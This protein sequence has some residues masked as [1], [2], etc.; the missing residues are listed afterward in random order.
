VPRALAVLVAVAAAAGCFR[1]GL[2]APVRAGVP[3]PR[4]DDTDRAR[5]GLHGPVRAVRVIDRS[6][7]FRGLAEYDRAGRILHRVERGSERLYRYDQRGRLLEEIVRNAALEQPPSAGWGALPHQTVYAYDAAGRVAVE[8]TF[9]G[10]R[11][12]IR[13]RSSADVVDHDDAL[14]VRD[15]RGFEI[16]RTTKDESVCR[17]FNENGDVV[18]EEHRGR[19]TGCGW[20]TT[21]QTPHGATESRYEYDGAGNWVHKWAVTR[22]W[23]FMVRDVGP[24][25][26]SERRDEA[27][28]RIDYFPLLEQR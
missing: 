2:P 22:S 5:D 21:F 12:V 17:R 8:T 16:E 10:E 15:A 18:E 19:A 23:E 14:V 6:G 4:S 9:D 3:A 27:V 11:H 7:R 24:M 13:R 28:R 25:Q 20:M 26:M 1:G